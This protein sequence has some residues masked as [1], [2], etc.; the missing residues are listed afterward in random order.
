MSAQL[1][2]AV[3]PHKRGIPAWWVTIFLFWLGWI[4]MYA[5]RTVL[6]PVMGEL[7]KEFG[8]S[9]TQLG[10]MNSVFYFSYALLQVPAGI[11]G[12]K[13]GKKK[14][15]IPGFLLFGAFTAVTGCAKSWSTLLFARVVTGAGEGTYYGPQYGLSSEQIPKN[16]VR[17]AAP[18]TWRGFGI[19]LGLIF[20]TGWCMTRATAGVPFFAMSFS[21]LTGLAIWQLSREK[22]PAR[23]GRRGGETEKQIHRFVQNRNLLLV[24]LMVFC[25]LFGFFVISRLPITQASAALRATKPAITSLVAG[26]QSLARCSSPRSP[27][28]WV[29]VSH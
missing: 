16:T 7:E 15:L 23:Q 27:T 2:D 12:D 24:Y 25:N 11:L 26:S 3:A 5:D 4:F 10:L 29:N 19:A 20:P 14:V 22:A 8:L 21:L 9:G 17:S 1:N 28:V 18:S 6:N 13:I